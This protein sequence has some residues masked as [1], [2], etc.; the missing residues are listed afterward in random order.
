MEN[1]TETPLKNAIPA[2]MEFFRN[3]VYVNML[4]FT[5]KYRI[6]IK[7]NYNNTKE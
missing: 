2:L 6:I 3:M 5:S 4:Y 1:A 7:N